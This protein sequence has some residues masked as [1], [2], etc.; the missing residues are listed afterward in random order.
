MWAGG[1]LTLIAEAVGA[2]AVLYG[3]DAFLEPTLLSQH[4]G[5]EGGGGVMMVFTRAVGF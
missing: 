4:L 1:R 2:Y 3:G 5:G